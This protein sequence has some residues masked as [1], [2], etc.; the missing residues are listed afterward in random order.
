ME[1]IAGEGLGH[2]VVS[3]PALE[4]A[5]CLLPTQMAEALALIHSIN[6]TDLSTFPPPVLA[7]PAVG[8]V[9]ATLT[10]ALDEMGEPH[11]AIEHG[12]AWLAAHTTQ[13]GAQE[14]EDPV[15]VHGDFRVGNLLIGEDGLRAVIDWE[16]A[17]WGHPLEDLAWPLVRAWRFG[18][19]DLRMGGI[20][21]AEAYLERYNT[22][23]GRAYTLNNLHYWEV[24]GNVRWAIS[25][26]KQ[27]R[28]HLDGD[29]RNV[30][31]AILGRF[32]CEVEAEIL[33][34]VDGHAYAR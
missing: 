19:P 32:C 27:A 23:A 14:I 30:E 22:L 11:P 4:H 2:R 25:C 17:H 12:L 29:E 10:A 1:R 26:L 28:R 20:G 8:R 16:F 24:V 5:R 31:L 9:L 6:P 34:L 7:G 15:L 21:L 13:S 18:R 3:A 33:H